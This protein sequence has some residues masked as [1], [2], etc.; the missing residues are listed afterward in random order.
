MIRKKRNSWEREPSTHEA[1][2]A[3]ET[4]NSH[5]APSP[6][7]I[8]RMEVEAPTGSTVI[9]TTITQKTDSKSEKPIASQDVEMRPPSNKRGSSPGKGKTKKHK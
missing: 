3:E 1:P 9:G 5:E 7:N 2:D 6:Q 8:N 4:K